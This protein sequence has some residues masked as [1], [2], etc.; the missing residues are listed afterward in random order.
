MHRY[1]D[2]VNFS[3]CTDFLPALRHFLGSFRLP[4][5]S[6]KIDRLMEKFAARYFELFKDRGIFATADAAYVL[7]YS[8]I[9]LTTDLHSSKVKKKISKDDFIKMTRGINDN[10]DLPRD[11]VEGIYDDI[12][13]HE[14]RLKGHQA[15]PRAQI[16]DLQNAKS[17]QALYEEERKTLEASAES[18]MRGAQKASSSVF[19][20]ATHVEHVRPMF[21]EV[22]TSLMAGFTRPL[23]ESED[24]HIVE[25]CLQ[26]MRICIHIACI[27]G[28]SLEREAFVP[29]LTNFTSLNKPL[30]IRA[31]NI[32]AI[33]CMLDVAV[34]DG[35]FL[36]DSW[37]DVLS[38]VSQLE[39]A[40]SITSSHAASKKAVKSDLLLETSSQDMVVATDRIFTLSRTLNGDAVVD[41]VR[42]LCAVSM[43]E[44]TG[45]STPR[46]YSLTKTVDISYY[47]MERVR[48]EWARIWQVLGEYFN[49]VGCMQN[50]DVAF[51]AVD[52]LR[53][54][55]IKFLEKG[56][57][58]NYSFQKDFLRP[59]EFIMQHNKS[60]KLRD[61]VVRCVGQMVQSK[62]DNIRSGWKNIFFVF[63]LAAQDSDKNIVNMAF[64]TTKHIFESYFSTK[65]DHRASHIAASFMDAVNCLSEFACNTHFP[66]LS[67]EAIRQLRNCA[68]AVADSPELFV[69]PQEEGEEPQIWVKGWFP[70]LFGLSRII[71]RCKMDVRTRALTVTFEVMKT[72][73]GGFLAQWW[74][75]LFR[76]I[77]RIFDDKKLRDMASEQE[78]VEWMST[79]CTHAL[80]SIIDVVS[81]YFDTLQ[82]CIM[83]ELFGWLRW[84][85]T[86]ENEQLARAGTECLH[87]MVMNNG[88]KFTDATWEA[89]CQCLKCLFEETEPRELLEFG[90]EAAAAEAAE[91]QARMEAEA[92]AKREAVLKQ[93]QA[94]ADAAARRQAEAK[95]EAKAKPGKDGKKDGKKAGKGAQTPAQ[96]EAGVAEEKPGTSGAPSEAEQGPAPDKA[97]GQASAAAAAAK[98]A[99]MAVTAVTVS[100]AAVQPAADGPTKV[101]AQ[102]K[103]K[104]AQQQLFSAIIIKC[105]VQLEL[106]QTVEWIVLSSTRPE[107]ETPPKRSL[108]HLPITPDN[109]V[110]PVS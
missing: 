110:T 107:S 71:N 95:A 81:Q 102:R 76:V 93:Q 78:R 73:G 15:A 37:K 92:Q 55:S 85:I 105:V 84:S 35:N 66:E 91:A 33:Q 104:A 16:A 5:E 64:T 60:V 50:E 99:D 9:M 7:A 103:Q 6:Q 23:M 54:L 1:V 75:D 21:K 22:W 70:V 82:E 68:S 45:G 52:S 41:F 43:E 77:F 79:T 67:M 13:A 24:P 48:L 39:Q 32:K 108:I 44:L 14:I 27:F 53:Q 18:A 34:R 101:N 40:Q 62:A 2:L 28:M 97:E 88:F 69:N 109:H 72:Y 100:A 11:F 12:A 94:E 29:A 106:I 17:R 59:F 65:H 96:P 8:V 90:R 63:S 49:R 56:E 87:I 26:G 31:K 10:R 25:L 51:F 4:G 86:R 89:S 46:K 42:A 30:D 57:L 47:N 38:T 74:K 3:Q 98:D 61:M 58:A 80:R 20:K 36:G 19:L 83:E